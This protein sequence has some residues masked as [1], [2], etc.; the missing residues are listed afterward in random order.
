MGTTYNADEIFEMAEEIERSAA[1]F[2]REAAKKASTRKTKR[3]FL[4]M[5]TMEDAHLNTFTEMREQ[6]NKM[7]KG[8]VVFDPDNQAAVYLQTI[9]DSHGC[10][11]KVSLTEKF[12]GNEKIQDILQIA[13]NAEKDSI[14][15]YVGLKDLVPA[16]S[17]KNKVEAIIKEEMSHLTALN[18]SVAAL[19]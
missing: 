2:Y 1:R 17:G 12:A 13:T 19:G 15:F 4:D 3:M 5:A 11:G 16:R 9:A 6:F 7:G 10:E 18:Q 14:I 8:Q